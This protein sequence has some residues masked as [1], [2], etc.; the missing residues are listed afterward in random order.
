MMHCGG[1]D[2]EGQVQGSRQ[3]I[4]HHKCAVCAAVDPATAATERCCCRCHLQ[5]DAALVKVILCGLP[6]VRNQQR[7]VAPH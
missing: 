4:K 6:V 3:A 2:C 5:D 7:I 1:R